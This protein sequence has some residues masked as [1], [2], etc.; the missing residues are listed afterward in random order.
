METPAKVV[1]KGVRKIRPPKA[2]IS[3]NNPF[4]FDWSPL[5]RESVEFILKKLQETFQQ[6]NL[7]KQEPIQKPRK[8][9]ASKTPKN[10]ENRNMEG[11]V[12]EIREGQNKI[13]GLK[14]EDKMIRIPETKQGW[15]NVDLRKQLA[16][17]I[18]EVTRGLEKDELCLVLVCRSVKPPIMTQHL[19][20][21]SA[22]RTVP[23]CQVPHLSE[24]VAPL[25]GL[26]STLALGF[27]KNSETF[28][29]TINAVGPQVPPLNISWMQESQQVESAEGLETKEFEGTSEMPTTE[30]MD[31]A[32]PQSQKRKFCE[33]ASRDSPLELCSARKKKAGVTLLPLKIKKVIPNPNKIRKPKKK[34]K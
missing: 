22:S 21:L 14:E 10:Q 13:E 2:K 3:F 26:K 30:E 29:E 25:L 23:A 27:K 16:I 18:N 24:T 20:Q 8:L 15:T 33:I 5:N 12:E 6:T 19:I 28:I 7:Y 31:V 11:N 1:Q 9:R 17:G 32:L 34:K 4:V